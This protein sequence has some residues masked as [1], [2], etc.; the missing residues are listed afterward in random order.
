LPLLLQLPFLQSE[1]SN[2][3]FEISA[4]FASTLPAN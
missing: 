1:I 3:K 2:L 4:A